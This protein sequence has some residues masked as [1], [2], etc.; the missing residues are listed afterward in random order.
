MQLGH[1][2]AVPAYLEHEFGK[3]TRKLGSLVSLVAE[4]AMLTSLLLLTV[5]STY[6]SNCKFCLKNTW[7]YSCHSCVVPQ[8]LRFGCVFGC[9]YYD[10]SGNVWMVT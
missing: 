8:L 1:L 6:M 3:N 10:G 5:R 7:N 9:G 2:L 4:S